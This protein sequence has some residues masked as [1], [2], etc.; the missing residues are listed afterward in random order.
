MD[1]QLLQAFLAVVETGSFSGAA[2]RM[3]VTQPAISKRIALLEEHLNCRLFDRISRTIYLTEAGQEL[4]PRAERILREMTETRQAIQ[5]LSGN[6]A[7]NLR[8]AISHHI[9]LHRLPPVLK[10]FA[11]LNP[12]VTLAVDFMDSEIAYDGVLHG[13]FE[14]AVITLAPEPHP[15]I[16]AQRIW[17]D[18]LKPMVAQDHPLAAK[19]RVDISDLSQFHAI[20][21][22]PDTY[23]GRMIK[24]LFDEQGYPFSAMMATNYL[25][26]IK[27]LVSVGLGWSILPVTM[28]DDSLRLLDCEGLALSRDLGF[29]HH[30]EKTLS[31]AAHAFISLLTSDA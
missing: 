7:G 10:Q 5:D 1:T 27:M 11:N 4:L 9:G 16:F 15:G 31:N 6:I 23:T 13:R 21:P 17:A 26:T 14:V 8:L 25:E 19:D 3:H 12:E 20:L 29:I 18:P 28:A 22:G 2:E 24:R 30:R